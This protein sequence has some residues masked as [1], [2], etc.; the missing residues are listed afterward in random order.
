MTTQS[1]DAES[2]VDLPSDLL[3]L[4]KG[5]TTLGQLQGF[6]Q[7]DLEK[8]YAVGHSLYMQGRFRDA[9]FVFGFL[10]MRDQVDARFSRAMAASLQM[11]KQ[12][13]KAIDLYLLAFTMD[14]SDPS[15]NLHV[16]ECLI[17]LGQGEA[18]REGLE[19]LVETT[20]AKQHED[21]CVKAQ[22]LLEFLDQHSA[23]A[24]G[25]AS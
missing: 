6:S 10:V 23:T 16:C 2:F 11:L 13:Q 9:M 7:D 22:A 21:L 3:E 17:A 24:P 19:L 1:A 18:A 5:G 4:F 20:D 8:I 12:Y 25:E 14:V 15:P